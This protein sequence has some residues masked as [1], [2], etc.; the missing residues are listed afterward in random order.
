MRATIGEFIAEMGQI[1]SLLCVILYGSTV[2]DELREESD[3]DVFLLFDTEHR[4]ELG[5]E[6]KIVARF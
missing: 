1:P 5:E 2:R 4:P 3:I 6:A